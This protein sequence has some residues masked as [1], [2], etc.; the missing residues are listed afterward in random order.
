MT[1]AFRAHGLLCV[2][3]AEGERERWNVP[4]N[5]ILKEKALRSVLGITSLFFQL[6]RPCFEAECESKRNS[7]STC[8]ACKK[9]TVVSLLLMDTMA[10]ISNQS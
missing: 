6:V 8:S 5:Q 3:T 10:S 2:Y 4:S 1:R 7:L 9:L